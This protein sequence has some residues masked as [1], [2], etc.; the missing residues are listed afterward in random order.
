M[1]ADRRAVATQ[2][3]RLATLV[4]ETG[5]PRLDEL[6]QRHPARRDERAR[7][8]R[9][10]QPGERGLRFLLRA[11][12][13]L[14]LAAST[15]LLP[16][17]VGDPR[18]RPGGRLSAVDGAA[19]HDQT[20][21]ERYHGVTTGHFRAYFGE[22][23]DVHYQGLFSAPGRIRTCDARFRKPMLYPLSYGSGTPQSTDEDCGIQSI[24]T[25][26]AE[27]RQPRAP[28]R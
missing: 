21:S 11:E 16:G 25:T 3:R 24:R 19:R 8:V 10:E 17:G 4:L 12:R 9:G 6:A 18:R 5:Q 1:R 2:R 13:T 26:S 28:H 7:L 15:A 27:H 14:R 20:V 22:F 23:A